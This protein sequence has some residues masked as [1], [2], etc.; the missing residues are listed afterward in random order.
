VSVVGSHVCDHRSY[1]WLNSSVICLLQVAVVA[2]VHRLWNMFAQMIV[3]VVVGFLKCKV[4][5]LNE[6]KKSYR[7]QIYACNPHKTVKKCDIRPYI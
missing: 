6:R 2:L 4:L 7:R 5:Y 3:F 1:M